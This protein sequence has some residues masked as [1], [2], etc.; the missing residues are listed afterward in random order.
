MST[1]HISGHTDGNERRIE[2]QRM[3]KIN[4]TE[5]LLKGPNIW[6]LAIIDNIDFK[7]TTFKYGNIFDT[8]RESSHTTLRMAFQMQMPI[9][10]EEKLVTKKI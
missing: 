2:K 1:L 8:T 10:L 9:S 5:R 4:P 3:T 7:E 6:N